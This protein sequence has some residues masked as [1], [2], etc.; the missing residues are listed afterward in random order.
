MS[1]REKPPSPGGDRSPHPH[2]QAKL[3]ADRQGGDA[4]PGGFKSAAVLR[5]RSTGEAGGR[6]RGD[7]LLAVHADGLRSGVLYGLR[8]LA[9]MLASWLFVRTT[10][11]RALVV[12]AVRLGIPYRYAWMLLVALLTI[13]VF[14]AE[15]TIVREAQLI[16]GVRPGNRLRQQLDLLGRYTRTLLVSGLRR[17]EHL[18]LAMDA[19]A[20]GAHPTRTFTDPHTFTPGGMALALVWAAATAAAIWERL[21]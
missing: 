12:A 10:S 13:P 21:A 15:Y 18:A 9:V 1:I 5:Q 4:A 7:R 8:V 3:E 16:R 17:V 6:R 19:R 11:P 2:A 14:E 20:F